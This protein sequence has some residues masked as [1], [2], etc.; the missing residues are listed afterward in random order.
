MKLGGLLQPL[1]ILNWKWDDISMDFIMGLLLTAR[2]FD[3]IWV[4]VD[5]LTKSAHF[6]PVN[7]NYKIQKYAKIYI[8]RVMYLH[9]VLKTII[10]DRGSQF[11]TRFWEP[12]HASLGTHLIHSST[13]NPQTD[14]Q[15]LE[16][17]LRAYV[18]E[19]QGSWDKN[20]P[21]TVFS[22]NNSY[23]ESLKMTPFEVL[24]G[25]QCH[26]PLNWI[27]PREKMIF[28]PNLIEEVE[29]IV[30]HIQDN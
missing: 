23:Q 28:G 17:M 30:S 2:K 21:W 29:V 15:I 8:T 9:G 14:D 10:S 26:T 19:H 11:V 22:Y 24:Y 5:R 18:M 6:V 3:L 16:V 13:Y 25:C 7:T 12:L 1:S 27:H 20:L 4:I